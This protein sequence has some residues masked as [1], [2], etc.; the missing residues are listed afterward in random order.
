[1]RPSRSSIRSATRWFVGSSSAMRS[2][3]GTA[4]GSGDASSSAGGSS[5]RSA[6]CGSGSSSSAGSLSVDSARALTCRWVSVS[7]ATRASRPAGGASASSGPS[8]GS[9]A[10][11]TANVA[12]NV[13]VEPTPAW[14]VAVSVPPMRSAR[15]REIDSPRP[16]PPCVR[17]VEAAA[18]TNGSK[19]A[20]RR[21]AETPTPVSR[22]ARRTSTPALLG[23]ADAVT[24]ISP[25]SVNLMAFES[26]LSRIWRTRA[27]SPTTSA[28]TLASTC[29]VRSTPVRAAPGATRVSASATST[30][31]E[32]G[33]SSRSIWPAS[34]FDRSRRSFRSAI[35]ASAERRIVRTHSCCASSRSVSPSSSAI[36]TTP[37]SGVRISWLMHARKS[38]RALSAPTAAARTSST[39]SL[40]AARAA[41]RPSSVRSAQPAWRAAGRSRTA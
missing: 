30:L 6:G 39:D 32:N 34:A 38:A 15:R 37:V 13:N 40:A 9:A 31:S 19:S 14:L 25:A 36:P 2:R 28:G 4:A 20:S 35:S 16:V 1:M 17:A 11:T 10:G 3:G 26:R 33:S 29:A 22:T 8:A 5:G 24:S 41:L 23:T 12:A 7:S 18:C 27:G 21:S